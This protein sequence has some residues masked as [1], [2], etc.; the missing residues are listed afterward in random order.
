MPSA[1]RT[2]TRTRDIAIAPS[3]DDIPVVVASRTLPRSP[4][5]KKKHAEPQDLIEIFSSDEEIQP[6]KLPPR[7]QLKELQQKLTQKSSRLEAVEAQL[8]RAQKEI[9]ELKKASKRYEKVLLDPSQLEDQLNCVV[10]CATNWTPYI[11]P[12]C[13]HTFCKKC[14]L[15]WFNTCLAQHMTACPNWRST[16]QPAYHRLD[17]R[18]RAHPYIAALAA[19]QGPQPN[20]SC[21]T[22]RAVVTTKP[23][24]DYSLKA[25]THTVA[26]SAGETNPQ[27]DP[28]VKR[29]GKGKAKALDGPFDGFFGK[30]P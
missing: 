25:L 5:K 26:T 20:F 14:L 8:E 29:R 16:N 7:D 22:C 12:N 21:P 15:E 11:L 30:E 18:I 10:C 9:S 13:G 2:S 27:K 23:I 24:E 3:D 1:R 4:P 6:R 28:V 17:P 19:A